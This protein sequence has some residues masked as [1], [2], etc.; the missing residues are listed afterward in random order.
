MSIG[1]SGPEWQLWKHDPDGGWTEEGVS[2]GEFARFYTGKL[3]ATLQ[4]N[5]GHTMRCQITLKEPEAGLLA[6][7]SGRCQMTDGGG[8]KLEF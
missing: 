8:V 2:V 3:V 6:G 7:G 4:G 5:R 1:W